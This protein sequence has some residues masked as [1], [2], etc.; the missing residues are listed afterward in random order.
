[1]FGGGDLVTMLA[2]YPDATEYSSLSLEGIGDPRPL[3]K[4]DKARL[5]SNLGK[6]RTSLAA[7]LNWAWNTT[8][9]LSDYSSETGAA[10]PGILTFALVALDVHGYEPIAARYFRISADGSLDYVTTEQV[11]QWDADQKAA[12]AKRKPTNSVQ[13]G[14]FSNVEIT[15]RKKGDPKAPSKV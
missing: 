3:G 14:L 5:G 10:I 11:D 12:K 9:Q 1:P 2:V 8:I 6:L 13:A 15:F 7:N 4:L